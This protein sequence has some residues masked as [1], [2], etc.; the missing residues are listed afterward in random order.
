MIKD[1]SSFYKKLNNAALI[2]LV[3]K[4][5]DIKSV[6]RT[7]KIYK[8][9]E[10][11]TNQPTSKQVASGQSQITVEMPD[12]DFHRMIKGEWKVGNLEC[13]K[14]P[15]ICL[16]GYCCPCILGWLN[17]ERLGLNPLLICCG[18]FCFPMTVALRKKI[19]EKYNIGGDIM[20]DTIMAGPI[21]G[22]L[23]LCQVYNE[24][25]A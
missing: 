12:L 7:S 19:R 9:S 13:L 1:I 8:M 16:L 24:I 4:V 20:D 23:S 17:A 3:K 22:S 18:M 14:N 25:D 21:V 15:P 2:L 6:G 11:V 5:F 10:P